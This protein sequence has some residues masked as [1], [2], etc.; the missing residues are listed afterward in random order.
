MLKILFLILVS[1]NGNLWLRGITDTVDIIE[2]NHYYSPD[3]TSS[4]YSQLIFLEHLP[5]YGRRTVVAW[6]MI[7][8]GDYSLLPVKRG[9]YYEVRWFDKG[10]RT[11]RTVRSK[12]FRESWGTVDPERVD[13]HLTQE[14]FRMGLLRITDFP[15]LVR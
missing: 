12:A 3:D 5:D 4:G 10:T 2:L 6:K 1:S 15:P 11:W 9:E 8:K 7:D 14:R 13:K